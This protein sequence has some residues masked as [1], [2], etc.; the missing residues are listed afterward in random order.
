MSSVAGG[1][2]TMS[3]VDRV[4]HTNR[5]RRK[6][7]AEKAALAFGMLLLA[8]VLPPWPAAPAVAV[9]MTLAALV[10]ARVPVGV[11]LRA[12][13]APAGFVVMGAATLLIQVDAG[14]VHLAPDHVGQA[15]GLI[16]RSLAAVTCLVFLALTTPVS[17]LV[18]GA[19]RIGVP[20]D[21]TDMAL[22]TYR[23]VFALADT[24][25][26][27]NAAQAARLGHIGFMRRLR[28]LGQL[29][30]NLLPRALER[31]RRL[32]VG[33]AARG[34]DGELRVLRAPVRAT[35]RGMALVLASE[36]AVGLLAW[37]VASL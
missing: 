23:F 20:A 24:A 5:W 4:S 3:P 22:I 13:A 11:W 28:S 6:P 33:L 2:A 14:G 12:V 18:A 36:A 10:G 25:R 35:A 30:A 19:R 8:I 16:V 7:L 17:D 21:V 15:A 27:M 29:V 9:L 32:E 1:R 37:G 34:F 26:A 31:A